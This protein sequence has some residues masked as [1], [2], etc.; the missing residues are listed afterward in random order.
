LGANGR[1]RTRSFVAKKQEQKQQEGA[2]Q[3]WMVT[4][5]G[6]KLFHTYALL[7]RRDYTHSS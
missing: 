2:N 4:Q 6:K 5:K 1:T 3:D 7:R